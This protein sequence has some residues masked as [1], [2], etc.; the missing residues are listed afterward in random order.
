[1]LLSL[2]QC[3]IMYNTLIVVLLTNTELRVALLQ[4][5]AALSGDSTT[6][7]LGIVEQASTFMLLVY[8]RLGNN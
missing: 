1:M 6:E 4:C 2:G 5:S 8:L 3:N 7:V